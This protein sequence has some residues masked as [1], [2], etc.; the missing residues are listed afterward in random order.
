MAG[1]AQPRGPQEA[2]D[3][4]A[5]APEGF[6]AGE[7]VLVAATVPTAQSPDHQTRQVVVAQG[8]RI[9]I[10]HGVD[11]HAGYGPGTDAR[12]RPQPSVQQVA[13]A[14]TT[15]K[16]T[17]FESIG[18]P[19][20][21]QH[22]CGPAQLDP[23][24]VEGRSPRIQEI[25]RGG[26]NPHVPL[27]GRETSEPPDQ[28]PVGAVGVGGHHLL[29]EHG[30]DGGFEDPA[31]GAQAPPGVPAGQAIHQRVAPGHESARVVVFADEV[32]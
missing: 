1:R 28:G 14:L 20:G 2:D 13:V 18:L 19:A 27:A 10:S 9:G 26:R 8:H 5:V 4:P 30:G 24:G 16:A 3:P 12:D 11:P 25:G 15:M 7:H 17:L 32:G 29:G 23:E 31:R 21:P 22:R 6:Q